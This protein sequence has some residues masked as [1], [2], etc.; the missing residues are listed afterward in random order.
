MSHLRQLVHNT[1]RATKRPAG[2]MQGEL[3]VGLFGNA[4]GPAA[5]AAAY[6]GCGVDVANGECLL[7]GIYTYDENRGFE[8]RLVGAVTTRR[9][10]FGGWSTVKGSLNEL[11]G[12]VDHDE[13][14]GFEAKTG[15]VS[16]KCEVLTV[17]G[18]QNFLGL[19]SRYPEIEVFFRGLLQ[20]PAGHRGEPPTPLAAPT[21]DD[22]TGAH[23]ALASLWFPD[24]RTHA[25]LAA[26]IDAVHRGAVDLGS[27]VDLVARVQVAHR[28]MCSGTAA[29]GHAFLSPLGADD[30]GHVLAGVLGPPLAYGNPQP[31]VHCMD[32]R[33]DTTRDALSPA[34]RALG[35]ASF[36]ALG[37]GFSPGRMIAADMMKKPAVNAIR[38]VYYDVAGG[39]AYE[40]FANGRRLEC[41]EAELAHALHLLLLH[42]AWPV[43]ERR[44]R[45]GWAM[46]YAELFAS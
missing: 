42:S 38:V 21:P 30:L 15:L 22:P 16:A 31:G 29:A 45:S 20:I 19:W 3:E 12:S 25:L 28:S 18:P 8:H 9:T 44:C 10:I 35:I 5:R 37:V 41:G 17:R 34:L 24:D 26:T 43:L 14:I 27:A 40:L 7:A 13:V 46:P 6:A 36:F 2:M 11:R 23:A 1:L 32:L 39:C 33:I 4:Q